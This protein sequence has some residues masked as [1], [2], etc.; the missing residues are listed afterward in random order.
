LYILDNWIDSGSNPKKRP[1]TLARFQSI[2]EIT[3]AKT[4]HDFLLICMIPVLYIVNSVELA[5]WPTVPAGLEPDQGVGNRQ[6]AEEQ[7]HQ[8]QH[9]V[10]VVGSE[11]MGTKNHITTTS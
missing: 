2:I 3:R 10:E 4:I 9:Q 6:R 8:Q 11:P 1:K 7:H 5:E